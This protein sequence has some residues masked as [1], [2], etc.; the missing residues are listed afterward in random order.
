[1]KTSVELCINK[2]SDAAAKSELIAN[3]LIVD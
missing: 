1:V 2:F 3:S